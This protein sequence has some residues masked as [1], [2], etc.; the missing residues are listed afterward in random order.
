MDRTQLEAFF[1]HLSESNLESI[2]DQRFLVDTF[3]RCVYVGDE[4]KIT[5]FLN[6]RG[7]FCTSLEKPIVRL[8]IPTVHH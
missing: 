3:V 7:Q 1:N 2:E 8:A 5:V 4:N 6:Y